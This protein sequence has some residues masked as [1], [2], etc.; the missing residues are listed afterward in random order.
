M[1]AFTSILEKKKFS[2][3][4]IVYQ[5]GQPCDFIYIVL[6]GEFIVQKSLPKKVPKNQTITQKLFNN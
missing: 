4:Q 1:T 2:K 6:K 3:D 5:E